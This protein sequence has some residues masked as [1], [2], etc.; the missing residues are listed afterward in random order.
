M[1]N[2]TPPSLDPEDVLR[3]TI[4]AKDDPQRRKR[5]DALLPLVLKRY[6]DW[7][8]NPA[9]ALDTLVPLGLTDEQEADLL[10]CYTYR[11]TPVNQLIRHIRAV[12]ARGIRSKCHYCG[13]DAPRRTDHYL[14]KESFAEFAIHPVNLLPA[15]TVC[16]EKKGK[17]LREAAAGARVVRH[18][19]IDE[20][21]AACFLRAR[22]HHV[23]GDPVAEFE[24][25]VG[26]I[27]EA[28]RK[29]IASHFARLG[30]LDRYAEAANDV[31]DDI[32][33]WIC[34]YA[35]GQSLAQAA[36]KLRREAARRSR[37]YGPNLWEG[38]LVR[39]L[40]DDDTFVRSCMDI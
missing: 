36:A 9:A 37:V 25:D 29:G 20:I 28:A 13:I 8:A 17:V 18:L 12:Q 4:D 24:L 26:A 15:C 21:P 40:A 19:Y 32:R 39:A 10:H 2:L 22:I 6:A 1:R 38:V 30:L 5:L 7:A 35:E 31:I 14:P 34:E 11:T 33:S 3:R 23:D 27:P 16:N